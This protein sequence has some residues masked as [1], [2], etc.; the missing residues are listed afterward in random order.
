MYSNDIIP[1]HETMFHV[2]M[3]IAMLVNVL[4]DANHP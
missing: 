3:V 1:I 4:D 2:T